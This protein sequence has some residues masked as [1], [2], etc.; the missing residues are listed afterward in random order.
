MTRLQADLRQRILEQARESFAGE[1]YESAT[2]EGLASGA[3]CSVRTL[4]T[5]FPTKVAVAVA[6][7]DH[8][9]TETVESMSALPEGSIASRYQQVLTDKLTQLKPYRMMAAAVFSAALGGTSAPAHTAS[10]PNPLAVSEVQV[11]LRAAFE[12][13]VSSASD[14]PRLPAQATEFAHLLFTGHL[15][16]VLFWLYD[17][18]ADGSATRQLIDLIRDGI[19]L[20]RPALVLPPVAKAL[21]RLTATLAAGFGTG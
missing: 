15:L 1:R 9:A 17:R 13:L 19:A 8:L 3:G 12:T 11:R 7:L 4:K 18:S 16:V 2:L 20:A 6:L 10:P 14:A 5:H 21:T